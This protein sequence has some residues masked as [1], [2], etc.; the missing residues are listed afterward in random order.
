MSQELSR[1]ITQRV[2][3]IFLLILGATGAMGALC[4]TEVLGRNGS[5]FAVFGFVMIGWI[6]SLCVHEFAHARTALWGGDTSVI[7]RGYLTFDVRRYVQ[8]GLSLWMPLFFLAI[9]GIGLPG[10]AVWINVGAIKSPV[11]RSLM[12]LAGPASNLLLGAALASTVKLLGTT[13][14]DHL[15]FGSALSYLALLQFMAAFLNLVPLPGLDG[16]GVI[17]PFLPQSLLERIAPFRGISTILLFVLAF[18][19][20]TFQNLIFGNARHAAEAFG[21]PIISDGSFSASLA[22]FGRA[23]FRSV[24][25]LNGGF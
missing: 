9:G 23:F 17:E 15:F 20:R 24:I 13:A 18:Q 11:R 4:W 5:R 10:G 7:G 8:P 6:A 21:V 2:S 14:T 12:S 3:P 22:D 25:D 16:F 1:P 19:S